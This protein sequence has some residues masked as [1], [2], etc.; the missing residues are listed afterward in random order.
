[1]T[2]QAAE[3]QRKMPGC[4]ELGCQA[5]ITG[6]ARYGRMLKRRAID[7]GEFKY[8]QET[9]AL[10]GKAHGGQQAVQAVA[11]QLVGSNGACI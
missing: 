9:S 7:M 4:P 1:M 5:P 2:A 10:L 8:A 11:Q 6:V 3:E